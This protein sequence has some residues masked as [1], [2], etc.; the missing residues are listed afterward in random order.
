MYM[1][2]DLF[3]KYV[4]KL[5]FPWKGFH[6]KDQRLFHPS[7]FVITTWKFLKMLC[8]WTRLTSHNKFH[9]VPFVTNWVPC[10]RVQNSM[11]AYSQSKNLLR[12]K[13]VSQLI[14]CVRQGPGYTNNCTALCVTCLYC[15]LQNG[16]NFLLRD[17]VFP[18][19]RVTGTEWIWTTIVPPLCFQFFPDCLAEFCQYE[20]WSMQR[21]VACSL[22]FSG[23]TESIAVFKMLCLWLEPSQNWLQKWHVLRA[24]TLNWNR[25]LLWFSLTFESLFLVLIDRPL[26]FYSNALD[27]LLLFFKF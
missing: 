21:S 1:I 23:E 17:L 22:L 24:T 9:S 12:A 3:T 25:L 13:M 7:S 4:V 16:I 14:C 10:L 26:S 6:L 5:E 27:F 18:S 19:S 20:S 2:G 8:R 11:N 15:P